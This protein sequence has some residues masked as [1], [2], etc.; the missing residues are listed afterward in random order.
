[1]AAKSVHLSVELVD[2]RFYFFFGDL[3][4][5]QQ[6]GGWQQG[7][8]A[9]EEHLLSVQFPCAGDEFLCE[10]GGQE[11]SSPLLVARIV[12]A[13]RHGFIEDEG[14]GTRAA[15]IEVTVRTSHVSVI[16]LVELLHTHAAFDFSH[17]KRSTPD[18]S[19]FLAVNFSKAPLRGRKTLFP[20]LKDPYPS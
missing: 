11:F 14:F 20:Y 8:F 16:G 4:L 3:L 6:L 9:L 18:E 15:C 7:F 2:A 10:G 19:L 1:M 5:D 12:H 13:G 17:L